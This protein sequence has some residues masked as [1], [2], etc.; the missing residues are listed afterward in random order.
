M[1]EYDMWLGRMHRN[2]PTMF[3][4]FPG[5]G[6]PDLKVRSD[7]WM[8]PAEVEIKHIPPEQFE[9]LYAGVENDLREVKERV[10]AARS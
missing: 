1:M 10:K 4:T 7:W 2:Y 6:R 9:A 5:E 3:G 8:Q